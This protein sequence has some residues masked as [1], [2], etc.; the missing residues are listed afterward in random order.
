MKKKINI[1]YNVQFETTVE[2]DTELPTGEY[3]LDLDGDCVDYD[4][5]EVDDDMDYEEL[6]DNVQDIL[7]QVNGNV[8]IPENNQSFYKQKSFKVDS[9][10][11]L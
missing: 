7:E 4:Y 9:F 6:E 8:D 5:T 2:I 11:I 3:F 1:T 10:E